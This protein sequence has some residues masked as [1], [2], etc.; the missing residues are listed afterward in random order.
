[1]EAPNE[2]LV[3]IKKHNESLQKLG[4][5]LFRKG[6]DAIDT[7]N[8]TWIFMCD[9]GGDILSFYTLVRKSLEQNKLDEASYNAMKKT[10]VNH[11]TKRT[12][13]Y[14]LNVDTILADAEPKL[15]RHM[16]TA[17]YDYT[18]FVVRSFFRVFDLLFTFLS[19]SEKTMAQ[20]ADEKIQEKYAFLASNTIE[21]RQA[22]R[23][24]YFFNYS[25]RLQFFQLDSR[26]YQ[27]EIRGFHN[28]LITEVNKIDELVTELVGS[29]KIQ[30]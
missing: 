6:A 26:S 25:D 12:I 4:S 3:R 16:S 30:P 7:N 28:M 22:M 17:M 15:K 9:L 1:M 11:E 13:E 2:I 14:Y 29:Q 19:R 21:L 20:H 18:I 24:A 8:K 27:K 5:L 23:S 10:I